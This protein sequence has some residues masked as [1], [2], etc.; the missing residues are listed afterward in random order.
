MIYWTPFDLVHIGQGRWEWMSVNSCFACVLAGP[1]AQKK[2]KKE[3]G[4]ACNDT[5]FSSARRPSPYYFAKTANSQQKFGLFV[6]SL[7]SLC[8]CQDNTRSCSLPP[9]NKY[10][11]LGGARIVLIYYQARSASYAENPPCNTSYNTSNLSCINHHQFRTEP[12]I[13]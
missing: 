10:G 6:I 4:G 11:W 3:G 2:I 13:I 9:T 1:S 12:S 5:E 7:S 8:L